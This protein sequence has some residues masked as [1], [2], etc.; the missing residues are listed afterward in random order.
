M[1]TPPWLPLRE[2]I[3]HANPHLARY[4]AP[5][6]LNLD[7][8]DMLAG[9]DFKKDTTAHG[10][11]VINIKRG[12]DFKEGDSGI[13]LLRDGSSDPYVSVGWAKFGKPVW[14]TRLLL[15]EMEPY[16]DETCYV[17]VTQQE[18]NVAE[19]IRVQLWDSDRMSADDDLG[20]IEVNLKELM[21]R[22]ESRSKMWQRSD[23]FRA[24]KAG[25]QMPGK[26]EWS[27]GYYPKTRIQNDQ[28]EKQ[29]FDN[30]VRSLEQLQKK[31][32]DICARKLREASIKAG[33]HSDDG[34]ELEQQKIQELKDRE[35]S[36]IIS[37]PPPDGYPSGIF[38]IQIHQ[39]TGLELAKLSKD[40]DAENAEASD[41]EEQGDGLP[42]AYCNVIINH[43][44]VFRTRTKPTNAKP[45]YNAGT[46]RFIGDWRAAEVHVAVRDARV[47]EDDAL[48]G[49]VH[50]PLAEVFKERA[51]VN[52]FYPLVGGVGY[53]RVRISMVWRSVQL[54]APREALGWEH[55]TLEI[56][57]SVKAS[58]LP[59]DLKKTK[60]KFSTSFA[61]GK[62]YPSS[63]SGENDA[64]WTPR[65]S[66][67]SKDSSKSN[68]HTSNSQRPL[69]LGVRTRYSTPLTL[70]FQNSSSTLFNK[71]P[72]KKISA[73]AIFWLKDLPDEERRT[74]TLPVYQG[75]DFERA[76]KCCLPPEQMGEKVGSVEVEVCFF[77]GLGR[78]HGKWAKK[79]RNVRN[80]VE[81][82]A[83]A[84][85]NLEEAR[86]EE[87][88]GIVSE[89]GS[90]RGNSPSSDSD[91]SSS[92]DHE[93]NDESSNSDSPPHRLKKTASDFKKHQQ[94]L[95]RRHRGI[96]QWRLPRTAKWGV[97][98]VHDVE[99]KFRG[100]F[101][102]G[103]GQG[104]GVETEV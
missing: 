101:R 60:V 39:I 84:R 96:M 49:I 48:L 58:N 89:S 35:D 18:L 61:K 86:E 4:V 24:L 55:G 103:E 42:S 50:L 22:E 54:Q 10:V 31:V 85:D 64:Q 53:G 47:K 57:P 25:E 9:D 23:G 67:K 21:R 2:K 78:A 6:S 40:A 30:H 28:L 79:D 41:E 44:K 97:G 26:L 59:P 80:V 38:S 92:E 72:N 8:K 37:A 82:L 36:M 71:D 52:G 73:Y 83:T 34:Q 95:G 45:F 1:G 90:A 20:R 19:R 63:S 32:D 81:V 102:H 5:K 16:W 88:A 43:K 74:L 91:S 11:L 51:Q 12:Y 15:N 14:S 62:M 27:V 68:Q 29:T 93:T 94:S 104:G 87:E 100:M 69:H 56:S 75:G 7:L 13:P 98:K 33:H 77:A 99:G 76:S 46:E 3:T 66:S 70:T 65:I 17:L